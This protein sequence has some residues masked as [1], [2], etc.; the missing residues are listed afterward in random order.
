MYVFENLKIYQDAVKAAAAIE[1]AASGFPPSTEYFSDRLNRVAAS[2]P[3]AIAEAHGHWKDEERREF[4]WKAREATQE[5]SGL[6]DVAVRQ[7][8]L[9]ERQRLYV[10]GCLDS[11][12][13]MIQEV[14]RTTEKAVAAQQLVGPHGLT[15]V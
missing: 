3:S 1:F 6:L 8:L 13:R 12:Q 10:R 14:L 9:D 15:V 4:F 2:I 7:G 5:C 11:V